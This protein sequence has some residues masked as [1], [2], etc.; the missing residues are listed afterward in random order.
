MGGGGVI[1]YPLK[2]ALIRVHPRRKVS[3]ELGACNLELLLPIAGNDLL[4]K[5]HHSGAVFA[6]G[7]F[8]GA[9]F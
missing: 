3:L 7:G 5:L 1:L 8:V 9:A 2:S 4:D 6:L